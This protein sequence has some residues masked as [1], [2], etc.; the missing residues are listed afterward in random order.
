MIHI[1]LK[2]H[3]D[4]TAL[5]GIREQHSKNG[6]RVVLYQRTASAIVVSWESTHLEW[7]PPYSNR[8]WVGLRHMLWTVLL[9]WW[10]VPGLWC[11]PAAILTDLFGGIDV[12]ELIIGP[13]PLPPRLPPVIARAEA[14]LKNRE[15]YMLILELILLIGGFMVYIAYAPIPWGAVRTR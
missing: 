15:G 8:T 9:G 3:P 7:V 11:A 2:K 12:T 13:P 6:G 4:M 14:V 1:H 10:S 5:A